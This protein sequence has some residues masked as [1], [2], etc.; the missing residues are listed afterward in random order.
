[1]STSLRLLSVLGLFVAL[2]GGVLFVGSGGLALLGRDCCEL[3]D[4]LGQ[5]KEER[6]RGAELNRQWKHTLHRD[7]VQSEAV[8]ELLDGR[9][10][11][12][13]AAAHFRDLEETSGEISTSAGRTECGWADGE[14]LCREI[15]QRVYEQLRWAD[16]EMALEIAVSLE[17]ELWQHQAPDGTVTLPR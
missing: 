14:R 4:L 17:A 12:L 2:A 5:L 7:T 16:P 3:P 8:A 10:S 1:M 6:H 11:L 13:Q 15:I 9:L